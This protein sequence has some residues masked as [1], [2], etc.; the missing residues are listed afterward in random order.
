MDAIP[1]QEKGTPPSTAASTA[2]STPPPTA[3]PGALHGKKLS[4]RAALWILALLAGIAALYFG[5]LFIVPV[6]IS[7][8]ASYTLAP[9]VRLLEKTRLPRPLAAL[10]VLAVLTAGTA[11]GVLS[12]RDDAQRMLDSLPQKARQVRQSLAASARVGPNPLQ[13]LRKAADEL[14]RAAAEASGT[15][16][17]NQANQANQPPPFAD[18]RDYALKQSGNVLVAVAAEGP[19]VVILTF[20]LLASGDHFRRKLM[21]VAGPSLSRRKITLDILNEIDAQVQRYMLSMV[22]SNIAAGLGIWAAFGL[23]GLQNAGLWG[24]AA[25]ILHFIPYLGPA[26]VTVA[27]TGAAFLQFGSLTQALGVAASSVAVFVVTGMLLMPWLQSRLSRI[28]ATVM[29][30]ALLFFGWLWGVWGLLLGAPLA[31]VAK[32]ICERV[33]PLRHVGEMMGD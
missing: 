17:G 32:V 2:A 27:A 25:G 22:A 29:F 11:W 4:P 23:F 33:E 3:A 19:V 16:N 10:L 5:R 12:L 30:V 20:F 21:S 18:L 1:P 31:A 7:I 28:N 15:N 8:L 24:T 6:L 14:Q 13:Q 9:V 26:M